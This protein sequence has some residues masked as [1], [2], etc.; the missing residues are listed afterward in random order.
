M[1]DRN[2]NVHNSGIDNPNFALDYPFAITTSD[3]HDEDWSYYKNKED[4]EENFNKLKEIEDD[5]HLYEYN[6]A[7]GYEVIDSHSII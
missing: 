5:I 1:K 7:L 6:M 3:G 4:A 2:G